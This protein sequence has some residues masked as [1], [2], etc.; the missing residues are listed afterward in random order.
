MKIFHAIRIASAACAFAIVTP[1]GGADLGER[2]ALRGFGT[3]AATHVDSDGIEFR[4]HVGQG[5]GVGDGDFAMDMDSIAG[6][7]LNARISPSVDAMVQVV[8]R[9]RAHG[10]WTMYASQAFVRW[11]PDDSLVLRAGRIGYDIYLLAESRQV[12]YSYV[13]IRPS[14]EFYG[15]VTNDEI[16]GGDISVTHRFGRSL[17]RARVFGGDTS[18]EMAFADGTARSTPGYLYGGMVDWMYRGWTTRAAIVSYHYDAGSDLPMLVGAL[19]MTGLPSALEVAAD[20]DH[21]DFAAQGV[22]LGVAYDDGPVL[23]QVLYGTSSSESITGPDFD[24]YYGLFGYRM[25]RWTPFVSYADSRDRRE[26][27]DAGLPDLPMFAPLN[28]AVTSIHEA[29]RSTM[30]TASAGVRYDIS[31]HV[32]FKLQVDRSH[33]EDTAL[34]FDRRPPGAGPTDMWVFGL[35]MDFVF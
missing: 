2:F 4:R 34:P 15:A 14:P 1:A 7:Q 30:R 22:Q 28:F 9:M 5:K 21:D 3:T 33:L 18:G 19:R 17:V 8:T 26:V 27:G 25:G 29:T 10:D 11:S 24:K 16:D 13:P 12:G 35:A 20:L 31:P 6:A 23:A 32:D